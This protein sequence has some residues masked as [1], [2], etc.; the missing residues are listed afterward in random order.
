MNGYGPGGFYAKADLVSANF[1][2]EYF[3]IIVYYD[4]LSDLPCQSSMMSAS[5]HSFAA[6]LPNGNLFGLF[7]ALLDNS[8]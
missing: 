4:R 1:D 8:Y 6:K 3:Y 2:N 7:G 5:F